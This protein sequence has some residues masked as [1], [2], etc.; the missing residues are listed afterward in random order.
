MTC[1]VGN[2]V[3]EDMIYRA[4]SVDKDVYSDELQGIYKTLFKDI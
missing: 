2:E 3:T 4:I 1:Y